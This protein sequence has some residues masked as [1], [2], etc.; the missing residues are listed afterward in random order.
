MSSLA[1]LD[2]FS[3]HVISTVVAVIN[4]TN[5]NNMYIHIYIYRY[6]EREKERD[7]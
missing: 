5:S 4:N 3:S 6:R 7:R 2:P 1:A